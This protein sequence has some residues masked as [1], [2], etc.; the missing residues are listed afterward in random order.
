MLNCFG[1]SRLFSDETIDDFVVIEGE[2]FWTELDNIIENLGCQ[3]DSNCE[4]QSWNYTGETVELFVVV[5][6]VLALK[7][8]HALL[9][10]WTLLILGL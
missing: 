8:S 2:I 3:E 9:I 6:I 4:S 5:V 10:T 1:F 7:Y